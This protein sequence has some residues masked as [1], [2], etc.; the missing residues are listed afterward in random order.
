MRIS[1]NRMHN[2]RAKTLSVVRVL[3]VLVVFFDKATKSIR[4]TN[5]VTSPCACMLPVRSEPARE[6]LEPRTSPWLSQSLFEFDD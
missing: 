4:A 1:S 3:R 6:E 2:S 5:S